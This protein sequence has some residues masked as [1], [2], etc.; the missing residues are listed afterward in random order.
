MT[1]SK[2]ENRKAALLPFDNSHPIL[3][4]NTTPQRNPPM[5]SAGE[6]TFTSRRRIPS[7]R[8]AHALAAYGIHPCDTAGRP[9]NAESID[10][11]AVYGSGL[12]FAGIRHQ[13]HHLEI[14]QVLVATAIHP[15]L[16]RFIFIPDNF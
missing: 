15:T 3:L 9:R 14:P 11:C 4:L 1:P 2:L 8:T 5:L 6:G 7:H 12:V 13:V 10:Q 16:V